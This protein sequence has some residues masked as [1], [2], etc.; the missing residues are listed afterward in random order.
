LIIRTKGEIA[1]K[2]NS[3]EASKDFELIDVE[4]KPAKNGHGITYDMNFFISDDIRVGNDK[5]V[6]VLRFR[7]NTKESY[8]TQDVLSFLV[9]E[10]QMYFPEYEC[11]GELV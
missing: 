4:I 10:I 2:V 7:A 8:I 3:F 9:S 6:M 1:R 11:E 5:K